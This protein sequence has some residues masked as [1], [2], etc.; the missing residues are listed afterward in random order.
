MEKIILTDVDG[1]LINWDAGFRKFMLEEYAMEQAPDTDHH[2][3]LSLRYPGMSDQIM[4]NLV[5]KMNMSD[6]IAHLDPIVGAVETILK[7]NEEGYKFIAITALSDHPKARKH[8]ATN[9]DTVFGT[10]IFDH[11]EMICINPCISKRAALSNW[12]GTGYFWIEDHFGNAE[13][14]YEVGLKPIL[15]DQPYNRH[16]QTDLFPRVMNWNEMYQLIKNPG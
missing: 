8:R 7:L 10:G 3:R 4:T 6:R 12:K 2:Y 15:Y 11:D 14:G 16:Y 5:T 1:V 13:A 9:L